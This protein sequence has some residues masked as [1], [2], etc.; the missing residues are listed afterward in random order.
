MSFEEEFLIAVAVADDEEKKKRTKKKAP[1]GSG[2]MVA[3]LTAIFTIITVC[4]I[5]FSL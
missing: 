5:V 4:M 2:C 3:V 1:Q